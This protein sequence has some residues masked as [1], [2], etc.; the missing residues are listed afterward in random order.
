MQG[1]HGKLKG[2]T[3]ILLAGL[4][5]VIVVFVVGF[6]PAMK[7]AADSQ[8]SLDPFSTAMMYMVAPGIFVAALVGLLWV[9]FGKNRQ[10]VYQ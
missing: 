6:Y 8:T 2:Q 10:V 7:I 9:A 3:A 5:V 1:N 4:V